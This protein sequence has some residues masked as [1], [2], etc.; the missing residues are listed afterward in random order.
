ML[1]AQLEIEGLLARAR[2][3][4]DADHGRHVPRN[5]F[6]VAQAGL[7]SRANSHDYPYFLH[8][9]QLLA[10]VECPLC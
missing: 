3:I 7:L 4:V 2:V 5:V 1:Q 10:G 9:K 6:G 8:I